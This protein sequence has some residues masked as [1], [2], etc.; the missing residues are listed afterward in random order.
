ML[1]GNN[2]LLSGA[3]ALFLLKLTL[4]FSLEAAQST[5]YVFRVFFSQIKLTIRL[6]SVDLYFGHI[7]LVKYSF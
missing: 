3:L 7:F 6:I 1:K 5:Y 2:P 4:N